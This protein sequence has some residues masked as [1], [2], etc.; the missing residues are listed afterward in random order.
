MSSLA[1]R[2]RAEDPSRR[3]N[4]G[5]RMS[6]RKTAVAAHSLTRGRSTAAMANR[7]RCHE[8]CSA[9]GQS[10]WATRRCG[11]PE[12]L[13][14]SALPQRTA[15]QKHALGVEHGAAGEVAQGAATRGRAAGREA[16]RPRSRT[17]RR[18]SKAPCGKTDRGADQARRRH[19]IPAARP[20]GQ[21]YRMTHSCAR[22]S[23][24]CGVGR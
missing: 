1:R 14:D 17:A 23:P 9:A 3:T 16:H 6:F 10:G 21:E 12:R 5:T 2:S 22:A 18:S 7:S 8:D 4:M 24:F 11:Q 19:A 20:S 13:S 15:Q